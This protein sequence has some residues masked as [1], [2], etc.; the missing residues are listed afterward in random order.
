MSRE[1]LPNLGQERIG[2]RATVIERCF[3]TIASDEPRRPDAGE[4]L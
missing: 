3:A 2:D 4:N 1:D